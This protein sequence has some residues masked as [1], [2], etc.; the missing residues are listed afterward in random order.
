MFHLTLRVAWHD[1]RW[2]G[3]ICRAP[4]LKFLLCFTGP[5]T[6]EKEPEAEDALVKRDRIWWNELAETELP[7]SG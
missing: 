6:Q 7:P 4:I 5:N 3:T 1:D 2:K